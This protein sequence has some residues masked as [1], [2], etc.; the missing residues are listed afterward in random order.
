MI[1]C[2]GVI[3]SLCS[4]TRI[5]FLSANFSVLA[6]A[7]VNE[8]LAF[9][10]RTFVICTDYAQG[11]FEYLDK[12]NMEKNLLMEIEYGALLPD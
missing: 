6:D 11:N 9:E 7:G 1:L 4:T 8:K 12:H 10:K 5:T 3:F 2:R